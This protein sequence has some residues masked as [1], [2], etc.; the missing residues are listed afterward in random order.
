V[1]VEL[2]LADLSQASW[3]A[4]QPPAK[5]EMM[6]S[7]IQTHDVRPKVTAS[8]PASRV[9]PQMAACPASARHSSRLCCSICSGSGQV[10]SRHF[11]SRGAVGQ[12]GFSMSTSS[13]G[14]ERTCSAKAED[15]GCATAEGE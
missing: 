1:N 10:N 9:A 13:P 4:S 5:M 11:Q 12:L 6:K 2:T 3:A 14:S 8:Q 7:G 15:I